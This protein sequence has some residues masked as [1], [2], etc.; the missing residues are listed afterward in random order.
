MRGVVDVQRVAALSHEGN[1]G[2]R[3]P[4]DGLSFWR[5]FAL[6]SSFSLS[7]STSLLVPHSS[8]I[9]THTLTTRPASTPAHCN[10][11]SICPQ[12]PR[13]GSLPVCVPL[14]PLPNSYPTYPLLPKRFLLWS[15][16]KSCNSLCLC[17]SDVALRF[18]TLRPNNSSLS[19]TSWSTLVSSLTSHLLLYPLCD[20]YGLQTTASESMATYFNPQDG[21]ADVY[22][23]RHLVCTHW[24]S[25]ALGE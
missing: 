21:A 17:Q 15:R 25:A 13:A 9:P 14:S 4:Q 6:L 22:S 20:R 24:W 5:C 2:R 19:T 7:S 1:S 11:A 10:R 12:S 3:F 18:S 16:F 23:Y 8:V